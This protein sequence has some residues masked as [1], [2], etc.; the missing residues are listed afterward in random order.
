PPANN[1]F[2]FPLFI[3]LL[4]AVY[5][6]LGL[7]YI[8]TSR[9]QLQELFTETH[10]F[11]HQIV[12]QSIWPMLDIGLLLD[13]IAAT[14]IFSALITTRPIATREKLSTDGDLVYLG[15]KPLTRKESTR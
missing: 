12:P 15:P 9:I 11:S 10:L 7:Q 14:L 3:V 2:C 13:F 5:G 6:T 4:T 1:H 8:S